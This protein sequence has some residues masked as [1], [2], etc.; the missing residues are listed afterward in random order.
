MKKEKSCGCI[1]V[2]D[3]NVLVVQEAEGHWGLPKGHVEKDETEVETA[4]REVK[5]ETNLDVKID[6]TKRYEIRYTINDKIDKTVCFFP[7]EIIGGELHKQD[8]EI[9]EIKWVPVKEAPSVVTYEI[10]KQMLKGAL[11]D[12]GY[13]K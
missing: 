1:I 12:L 10:L 13:V 9:N 2:K 11:K 7:A 5:E 8:S 4:K 3:G 6:S